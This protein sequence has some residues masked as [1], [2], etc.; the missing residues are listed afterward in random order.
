MKNMEKNELPQ[1]QT[2]GEDEFEEEIKAVEDEIDEEDEQE[3]PKQKAQ[4]PTKSGREDEEIPTP[5]INKQTTKKERPIS[6]TYE[7]FVQSSRFGLTNTVTGELIEGF[8]EKKD[9]GHVLA[10]KTILNQLSK[11]AISLGV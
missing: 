5:A 4:Y 7:A 2:N 3:V 6:E 1:Q 9:Q 8:D 11:I 10:Y